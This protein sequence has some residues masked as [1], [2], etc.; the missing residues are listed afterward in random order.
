LL[1]TKLTRKH[2]TK[3]NLA[4]N[5]SVK[6]LATFKEVMRT[7]SISE[8]A[9][10]LKRTQPAIS[11]MIN[12]LEEELGFALFHREH[13]KLTPTP[14]AAYL[15][16]EANALL[17]RLEQTK[18]ILKG[19]SQ[20]TTGR[21]RVAC[22]PAASSFFVP[23]A[24]SEFLADKPDVNVTLRAMPSNT[25]EDLVASNQYDLGFNESPHRRGSTQSE[26]FELPCF[27][28]MA[29][30][31]PLASPLSN[32]RTIT[33]VDLRSQP[34]ALLF[35]DHPTAVQTREAFRQTDTPLRQRFELQ[36][37]MTGLKFVQNGLCYMVCDM[38]TA[39]SYIS[40]SGDE[41]GVIFRPF[42]PR[43]YNTVSILTP[44]N[45]PASIIA[46]GLKT[47]LTLHIHRMTNVM[48]GTDEN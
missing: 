38:L 45:R 10:T 5:L 48:G 41:G 42:K 32:Q 16:E 36:T 24:L 37:F 35:D 46:Q 44:A 15:L 29:A 39:Y 18:S 47:S 7:G 6:Q 30:D 12:S 13:R 22:H 4:M 21:L 27:C 26:D 33:P 40:L 28:A 14:E 19:V 9:R 2:E 20:Q 17:A 31:S 23:N 43:V 34:M 25:I 11:T 1:Y 8:A 3:P